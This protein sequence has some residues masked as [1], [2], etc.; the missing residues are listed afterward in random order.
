M[1]VQPCGTVV[2]SPPG[3][4]TRWYPAGIGSATID[5]L[6]VDSIGLGNSP[7]DRPVGPE[8]DGGPGR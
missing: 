6:G 2:T 1:I 4:T 5:G 8:G 7:L 3:P